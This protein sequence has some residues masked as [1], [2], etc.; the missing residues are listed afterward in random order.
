MKLALASMML[1]TAL[2][3]A[4]SDASACPALLEH[5]FERLQSGQAESLCGFAGK[6][7]LVVNTASQCGYTGQ[8]EGLE[9]LGQELAPRGFVVLGFPSN[10][11]G[12]QE[13]GSD[14][15]IAAFC[16]TA[17]G[18]RFP[19]FSK[20]SVRGASANPFFAALARQSGEPP[21]WNFHKYLID[22]SGTRVT[23]YPSSERPDSA[24]LRSDIERLLAEPAPVALQSKP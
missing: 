12:G 11:F 15:E 5:R 20:S 1:A 18:I 6:V 4:A 14:V 23:S 3:G 21:Q 7:I 22:R 2:G 13:P 24:A 10:D 8:Y 16:R 9:A 17:Y 19:M